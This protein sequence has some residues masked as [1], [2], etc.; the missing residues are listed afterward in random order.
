MRRANEAVVAL[1][2]ERL[3]ID[4][5]RIAV[6]SSYASPATVVDVDGMAAAAIRQAFSSENSA[7][8][9]KSAGSVKQEYARLPSGS[10]P[11]SC[12]TVPGLRVPHVAVGR[13]R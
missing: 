9:A 6:V 7:N 12:F 4:A 2:T 11:Y 3:G 8:A 13:T 10:H 1:L 5:S